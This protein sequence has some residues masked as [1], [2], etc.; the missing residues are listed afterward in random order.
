MGR[1]VLS[2]TIKSKAEW[3]KILSDDAFEITRNQGTEPAFSGKYD[4][5]FE[6]GVY[7]CVCCNK[8]LFDS[9]SKF[10]SGCGWPSYSNSI[11]ESSLSESQDNSYDM[12]R[13]EVKCSGCD[14]HLGHVFNDGPSPGGLR[15]CIN[16][17]AITFK[18]RL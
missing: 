8:E 14:A 5:C 16:S 4:Q 11:E 6:D 13:T 10:N 12:I 2:K 7:I 15:Y 18:K 1:I 3:K 17:V 9:K